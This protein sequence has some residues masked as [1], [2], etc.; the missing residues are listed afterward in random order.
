ML[1]RVI[2]TTTTTIPRTIIVKLATPLLRD[3]FLAKVKRFNKANPNDKINT[4]HIGIG[5]TKMP[6]YVLEHLSPTNKKV[7]A[8][9]RQRKPDKELKFVWIKQ[10]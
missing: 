2:E 10:G 7:H 4:N 9:A 5:G 6:V 8:A 3:T 1:Q